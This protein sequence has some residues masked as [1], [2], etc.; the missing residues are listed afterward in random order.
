M[1]SSRGAV[2]WAWIGLV[3]KQNSSGGKEK[4]GSISNAGNRLP[5][6]VA[7]SRRNGSYPLCRTERDWPA[8]LVQLIARQINP[9]WSSP[10]R[11]T[12][13]QPTVSAQ[14]RGLPD[15][16]LKGPPILRHLM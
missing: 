5:A 1:R 4:L 12:N 13:A 10:R 11:A 3:P 2:C 9:R 8:M 14:S 6:T 15:Q 7:P 16:Q